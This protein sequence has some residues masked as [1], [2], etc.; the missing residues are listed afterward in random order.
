[1]AEKVVAVLTS[2]TPEMVHELGGTRSWKVDPMN[3]RRA[4][5][6]VLLH[7]AYDERRPGDPERHGHPFLVGKVS[8]LEELEGGRYLIKFSEVAKAD[9]SYRWPGNRNPV[10][11]VDRAEVFDGL[12]ISEWE[13][14]PVSGLKTNL[15]TTPEEQP[16][17]TIN[18]VLAS[19]RRK[20][21]AE[22][23]VEQSQ[24]RIQI[25]APSWSA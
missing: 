15:E 22:L 16:A 1:M 14:L 6:V 25:D 3:V 17:M 21:A 19:H 7:N 5:T 23:G 12:T 11:Y 10:A 20:I 4:G 24:V 2:K 18:E 9:G 13:E 8:D